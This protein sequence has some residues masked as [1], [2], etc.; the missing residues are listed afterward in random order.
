METAGD[1]VSAAAELAAGVE[2]GHDHF[3]GRFVHLRMLVDRDTAP[4]VDD[5]HDA[6]GADG[7]DDVIAVAAERLVDRVVDD[8]AD[9]VMQASVIGAADVHARTP[10]N[11]FESFEDLD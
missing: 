5:R 10:S 6:V 3:E 9:E 7:A 4:V 8:L 2:D 1:L 11:R